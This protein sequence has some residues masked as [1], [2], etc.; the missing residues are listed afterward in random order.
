MCGKELNMSIPLAFFYEAIVNRNCISE[1]IGA[2]MIGMNI[3]LLSLRHQ[4]RTC[5]VRY[6]KGKL[7]GP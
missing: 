1:N 7:P 6:V 2:L 4:V 3:G 5:S